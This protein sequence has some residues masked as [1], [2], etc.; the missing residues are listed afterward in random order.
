MKLLTQ[1]HTARKWKSLGHTKLWPWSY[2]VPPALLKSPQASAARAVLGEKPIVTPSPAPAPWQQG[3][4]LRPS[5]SSPGSLI[6]KR[7]TRQPR[8]PFIS[9]T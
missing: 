2:S 8:C 5:L 4:E 3:L 1:G 7:V 6:W 9:G